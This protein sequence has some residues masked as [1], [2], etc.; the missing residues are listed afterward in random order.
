MFGSNWF[1]AHVRTLEDEVQAYN[2]KHPRDKVLT[3]L[4]TTTSCGPTVEVDKMVLEPTT[5]SMTASML[6]EGHKSG[7]EATL[8]QFP[9]HLRDDRLLSLTNQDLVFQAGGQGQDV[10]ETER[11]LLAIEAGEGNIEQQAGNAPGEGP[12]IMLAAEAAIPAQLQQYAS[13]LARRQHEST[14]DYIRRL[15][16]RYIQP[17]HPGERFGRPM[18]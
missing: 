16:R 10:I 5:L 8:K 14:S 18:R 11:L 2:K 9:A 12:T 3:C 13:R 17:V 4:P 15:H 6:R 7:F 1:I